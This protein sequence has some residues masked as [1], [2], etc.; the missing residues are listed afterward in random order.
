MYLYKAG[1][2]ELID[3]YSKKQNINFIFNAVKI[4]F[5]EKTFVEKFFKNK[6]NPRI[7]VQ[8]F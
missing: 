6:S 8:Y 7:L 3:N 5:E 2:Q 4:N 1:G